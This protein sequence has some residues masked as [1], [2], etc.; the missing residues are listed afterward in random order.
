M[1]RKLV[2][3]LLLTSLMLSSVPVFFY[4]SAIDNSPT[5][6][7]ERPSINLEVL[8]EKFGDLIPVVVKFKDGMTADLNRKISEMNIKFTLGNERMRPDGNQ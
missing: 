4:F 6:T 1:Q 2:S 8:A 3:A 5:I 7:Y